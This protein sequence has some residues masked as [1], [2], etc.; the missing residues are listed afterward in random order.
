MRQRDVRTNIL[1][2]SPIRGDSEIRKLQKT[3]RKA[4]QQAG[5]LEYTFDIGLN[6]EVGS[7]GD[8]LS[9]GQRQKI[10]IARGLLRNRPVLILDEATASLDNAS[11]QVV[12]QT[13]GR[14]CRGRKTVLA[15]IHRLDLAPFYDRIIVMENGSI[16]EDGSYEKL[17]AVKGKFYNLVR[18]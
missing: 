17:M 4:F 11:Q 13:I 16:V 10:A 5:L 8:R 9:G 12:Q 1:F 7:K 18:Q 3:A 6:F 14:N 15:V 2:G